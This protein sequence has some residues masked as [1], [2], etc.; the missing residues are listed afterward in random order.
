QLGMA[1]DDAS[2][3]TQPRLQA[4][5]AVRLVGPQ[6]AV[7]GVPTDH[8]IAAVGVFMDTRGDLAND[9]AS[10]PSGQARIGSFGDERVTTDCQAFSGID[11]HEELLPSGL[12]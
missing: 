3:G 4:S 10:L 1:A 9:A 8:P 12:G 6:P 7:Q 11:G 5:Q 2:V